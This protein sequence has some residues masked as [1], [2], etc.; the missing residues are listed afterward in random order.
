MRM[1]APVRAA[2]TLGPTGGGP[3]HRTDFVDILED[4]PC[5]TTHLYPA[6]DKDLNSLSRAL[7]ELTIN[8]RQNIPPAK[9]PEPECIKAQ[10][11][12][13]VPRLQRPA[14]S[15]NTFEPLIALDEN[16]DNTPLTENPLKATSTSTSTSTY[17][18]PTENPASDRTLQDQVQRHLAVSRLQSWTPWGRALRLQLAALRTEIRT[19]PTV[20]NQATTN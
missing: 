5:G 20:I 16:G 3:P 15:A 18:L 17:P 9:S 13:H 7:G 12:Q 6:A 19:H 4:G 14:L 2:N 11:E 8:H 1:G 10:I